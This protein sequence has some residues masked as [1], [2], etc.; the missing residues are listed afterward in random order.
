MQRMRFVEP[1]NAKTGRRDDSIV[2]TLD[3]PMWQVQIAFSIG[4]L[5]IWVGWRGGMRLMVGFYDLPNATKHLMFGFVIGVISAAFVRTYL[6]FPFLIDFALPLA[7]LGIALILGFS[8]SLLS[9]LLLTRKSVRVLNAQPT[10]G[11]ALGLGMGAMETSVLTVTLIEYHRGF[12][13]ITIL[14]AIF[15]AVCV[16]WC[17]AVLTS[18]QG[19]RTFDGARFAPAFRVG[20]VRAVLYSIL[21]Y[22]L[23]FPPVLLCLPALMLW[24]QK[25][26]DSTWL[27]AS[28]SPQMKQ[29]WMRMRRGRPSTRFSGHTSE[30]ELEDE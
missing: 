14:M 10:S 9:M 15:L 2:A 3:I 18:Y 1:D 24:G 16:P 27:P 11:W 21:V 28:L 12:D 13:L 20:A 29:E 25:Q 23:L 26:A 7:A 30:H 8:Q 6:I 5:G 4:I 22:S 19:Y 17:E